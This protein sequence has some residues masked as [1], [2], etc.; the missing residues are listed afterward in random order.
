MQFKTLLFSAMLA[1]VPTLSIAGQCNRGS[2]EASTC[3]AGQVWNDK[4][5]ACVDEKSA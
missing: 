2:H 1:L 3:A 5:Q 4:L